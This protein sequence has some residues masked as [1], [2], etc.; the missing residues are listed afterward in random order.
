MLGI[1]DGEIGIEGYTKEQILR[2]GKLSASADEKGVALYLFEEADLDDFILQAGLRYD[3]RSIDAPLDGNNAQFS[4]IFD[5]TNNSRD[6]SAFGG[7]LGLTYKATEH[8]NIAA[9]LTRGFRAPSIF[10]LYAGG[11][12]GGVQAYQLG[13]PD[14]KEETTLGADLSFRYKDETKQ[15]SL[16]FYH[17]SIDDYI[18]LENTGNT[19]NNL[20]EMKNQQTDARIQGIEFAFE[21]HLTE[22]TRLEGAF[23]IIKGEDTENDRALPLMPANN[24]RLALHHDFGSLWKLKNNTLSVDMKYADAQQVGGSYEPFSQYN[25][26]PFGTADTSAYTLWGLGYSNNFELFKKEGTF[27]IKANNLFNKAYR[28]FLD[29]YKGYALGM[30]RD[31]SF[32]VNLKF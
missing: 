5:A 9:N 29:T 1:F 25:T 3:R 19:V 12:H 26:M 4:H 2:E 22:A 24:A 13:N 10:E 20:P 18:Y 21:M 30:G 23:E 32:S 14:L 11:I 27:S 16:T 8:W 28:D 6:F 17:T 15:A 7:S 31:V